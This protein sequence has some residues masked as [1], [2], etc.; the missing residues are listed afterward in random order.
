MKRYLPLLLVVASM[1]AFW[2]FGLNTWVTLDAVVQNR[3]LLRGYVANH[4]AVALLGFAGVYAAAVAISFPGASFLTLAAG[5]LFG[6]F[7]GGTTVVIAA[8][9]GATLV[10]LAARTSLGEGL[11]AKAGP[12]LGKLAE[13][14]A[15]DGFLYLLVLRLAPVFP[16][17]LIN[18]APALLGVKLR[19]YVVATFIGI[20]P[21]TF[22]YAAI[23][24][25]LDSVIVAQKVRF[26]ACVASGAKGCTLS[27]DPKSL[28]TP[29]LV[30]AL[31]G[32]ALVALI[33]VALKFIRTRKPA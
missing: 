17:W 10:F 16:F 31:G 18:L 24:A 14:F 20:I 11:A 27:I 8:T 1:A 4:A 19:D 29:E 28:V 33:P 21:G 7:L 22:A 6:T 15:K 25:G 32:L 2:G 13:G 5:F 26:D 9:M 3:D 12:W 30:L 23:G